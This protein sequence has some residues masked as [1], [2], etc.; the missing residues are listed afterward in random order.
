DRLRVVACAPMK[1]ALD[2]MGHDEG[3]APLLAGAALA[4]RE[5]PDIT[6]LYL[7]GDTPRLEKELKKIDCNDGRIEIVH[8]TQVVEMQDSAI[9]AVRR[10]KDSSV[11]RA[12]EL[13]KTG[14]ADAIVSAGHTGAAVAA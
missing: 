3:P 10:K 12:V 7:T 13:V 2:A 9:D 5:F 1:I 14:S 11:G 4:L 8:A 6:R